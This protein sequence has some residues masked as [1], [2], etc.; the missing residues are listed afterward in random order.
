MKSEALRIITLLTDFGSRD[1]YVA[2]MKGVIAG[3]APG[4]R[5]IDICHEVPPGDIFRAGIIWAEATRYYPPGCVHVAVVDPGVGTRR[6]IL[7]IEGRDATYLAPDNGVVGLVLSAEEVR[8]VVHVKDPRWFLPAV[9]NTFHG[10][11]IFSPVAARLSLG[12]DPAELGSR[13]RS[14]KRIEEPRAQVR[15]RRV[16]GRSGAECV[17]QILYLDAFGNAVT[18]LRTVENKDL[19]NLRSGRLQIKALSRTYSDVPPGRPLAL[20]GSSGRIEIA[21]SQS[22]AE[23][24]L[25]LRPGDAVIAL[26]R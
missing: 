18:N 10:R 12:L 3:I 19:V 22:N 4:A 2:A 15:R 25:G 17:G 16:G 13:L 5:V 20:V 8:Q 26:W 24:S 21:V 23:R 14:Y 1:S 9:S 11:D 6:R 7:A